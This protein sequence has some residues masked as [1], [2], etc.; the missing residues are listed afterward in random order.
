MIFSAHSTP[1]FI[2]ELISLIRVTS[3]NGDN[4]VFG[5]VE[6]TNY[7]EKVI[8]IS[9]STVAVEEKHI[10]DIVHCAIAFHRGDVVEIDRRESFHNQLPDIVTYVHS[11]DSLQV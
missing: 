2:P 11:Q 1:G 4:A 8:S 6:I 9:P 3:I 5:T 7:G 10:D